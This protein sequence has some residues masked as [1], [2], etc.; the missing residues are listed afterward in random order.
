MA[1][2]ETR[3]RFWRIA[4]AG[5][6]FQG[7][8]AAVDTGTIVAALVNGLTGSPVAVGA[9]AAISRYGWLA[10]QLFVAYFAQHRQRRLPFYML[11][12]FG[13]VAC[14]LGVA[15]VV[16]FSGDRKSQRLNSSP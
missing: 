2:S 3:R 13:R 6:F 10:P 1:R 11:G 5:I 7:G 12:A 14:L 9:A 8:A 4:T 15:A 16:T